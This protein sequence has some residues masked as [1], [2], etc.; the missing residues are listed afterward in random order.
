MDPAPS[1]VIA[2]SPNH[3]TAREFPRSLKMFNFSCKYFS[4]EY[5]KKASLLVKLDVSYRILLFILFCLNFLI[6]CFGIFFLIFIFIYLAVPVLV[7]ARRMFVAVCGIF[8]AA[9]GI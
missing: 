9:C 1:A 8:V 7:A 6:I 5:R 3:W 2:R 4:L